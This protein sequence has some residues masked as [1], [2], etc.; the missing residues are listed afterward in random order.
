MRDYQHAWK[1]RVEKNYQ[2]EAAET[3]NAKCPPFP[4]G[5]C[6]RPRLVLPYRTA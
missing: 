3:A 4:A 1:S 2:E 5:I 6:Q